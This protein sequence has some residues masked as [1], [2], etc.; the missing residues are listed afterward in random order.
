MKCSTEKTTNTCH[1]SL[2]TNQLH[3]F[4][5][6]QAAKLLFTVYLAKDILIRNILN[7][8][9][10]TNRTSHIELC[11]EKVAIYI[12]LYGDTSQFYKYR[13]HKLLFLT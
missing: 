2:E 6:F 9:A 3:N 7:K 10:K 11:K 1:Y 8:T 12:N 4:T 5:K 13:R